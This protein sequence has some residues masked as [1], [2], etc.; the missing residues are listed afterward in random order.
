MSDFW[1]TGECKYQTRDRGLKSTFCHPSGWKLSRLF[2][3]KRRST[4]WWQHREMKSSTSL[5]RSSGKILSNIFLNICWCTFSSDWFLKPQPIHLIGICPHATRFNPHNPKKKVAH[6]AGSKRSK[7][8]FKAP[9]TCDGNPPL[10]ILQTI[11]AVRIT[12]NID[13]THNYTNTTTF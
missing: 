9:N 8:H 13:P 12:W 5:G 11:L 4:S 3:S 10:Q 1:C 2:E 7:Y 6:H